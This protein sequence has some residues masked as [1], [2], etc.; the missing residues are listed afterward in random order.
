[1]SQNTPP[2]E[3]ADLLQEDRSFAPST[4]FQSQANI[5][6][7]SVYSRAERDPDRSDSSARDGTVAVEVHAVDLQPALG[8]LELRHG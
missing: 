3:I 1:M 5:R 2:P 8:L 6:D 7:E 4:D